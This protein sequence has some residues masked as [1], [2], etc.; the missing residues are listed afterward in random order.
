MCQG[1][2]PHARLVS[3]L[4]VSLSQDLTFI[5]VPGSGAGTGYIFF[6]Y[7]RVAQLTRQVEIFLATLVY[8]EGTTGQYPFDSG[9]QHRS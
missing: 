4:Q 8:L 9:C 1:P 2:Q 6:D 7:L 5:L 3:G